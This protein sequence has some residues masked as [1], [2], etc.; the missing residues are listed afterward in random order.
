MLLRN[1][2]R[3]DGTESKK[4]PSLSRARLHAEGVQN[5]RKSLQVSVALCSR[6]SGAA[7]VGDRGLDQVLATRRSKVQGGA[8]GRKLIGKEDEKGRG[9]E[10]TRARRRPMK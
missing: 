4:G 5:N 6:F 2:G 7:S 3:R 8:R 1:I 9:G 10:G